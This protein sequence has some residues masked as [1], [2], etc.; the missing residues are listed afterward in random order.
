MAQPPSGGCVLK[1]KTVRKVKEE[2]A[3]P[4]SGGCVL[5]Q[6]MQFDPAFFI[7]PAAF[8]RLCVET[9]QAGDLLQADDPAAFGRLCVE[10]YRVRGS[11]RRICPA[12]FGRLCVETLVV[13]LN[14]L[15]A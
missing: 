4:P 7:D 6:P 3:Q 11:A 10:T 1:L 2:L 14:S 13:L 12:A 9:W 15:S 5:K 8:G